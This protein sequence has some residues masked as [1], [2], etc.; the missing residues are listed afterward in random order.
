MFIAF[1]TRI[2][3]REY[4]ILSKL[5]NEYI[6]SVIKIQKN[7]LS[8]LV[9]LNYKQISNKIKNVYSLYTELFPHCKSKIE[10]L[11]YPQPQ[12]VCCTKLYRMHY[13]PLR[14]LYTFDIPKN[15]FQRFPSI[16]NNTNNKKLRFNFRVNGNIFIDPNYQIINIDN[17][18][19]NQ[20]DFAEVDERIQS[21]KKDF[22]KHF[23]RN[24]MTC[25]YKLIENINK[26]T[27]SNELYKN[28]SFESEDED[29]YRGLKLKKTVMNDDTKSKL[30][31]DYSDIGNENCEIKRNRKRFVTD[32]IVINSI[33]K[34]KSILKETRRMS[35]TLSCKE[36]L[37][38]QRKV[39]FGI[40]QF[41]Y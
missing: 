7:Y 2:K 40:V 9:S 25:R 32:G 3:I 31:T 26:P 38:K 33:L 10:L 37:S 12:N 24:K 4:L 16:L 20:I 17:H 39:S 15:V 18:Y 19:I 1:Y 14:K 36:R 6:S 35:G 41:S 30:S 8:H 23:L 28:L 11:I 5:R 21:N 27:Y 29:E 34:I 13:C 22:Q